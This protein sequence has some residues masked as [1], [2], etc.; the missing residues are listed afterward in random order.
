[1]QECLSK[2]NQKIA[3]CRQLFN[4]AAHI[5]RLLKITDYFF[6]RLPEYQIFSP[7]FKV[8][9]FEREKILPIAL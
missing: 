6:V 3:T 7:G 8:C 1:M 5:T 4:C 2:K 9:F